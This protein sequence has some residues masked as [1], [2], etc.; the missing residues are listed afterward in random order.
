M[1]YKTHDGK[2]VEILRS[3]YIDDKSY[4]LAILKA[5]VKNT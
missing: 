2:T 5:K 4:Y 3:N 1:L